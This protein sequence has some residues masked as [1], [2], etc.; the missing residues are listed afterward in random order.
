MLVKKSPDL[1]NSDVTPRELYVNRRKFLYGVGIA[2]GAVVAGE[3]A[4]GGERRR[5]ERAA[6]NRGRSAERTAAG[7]KAARRCSG[8][9]SRVAYFVAVWATPGSKL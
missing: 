3:I 8:G 7:R 5:T 2:G 6:G 4:S 9:R 1:K